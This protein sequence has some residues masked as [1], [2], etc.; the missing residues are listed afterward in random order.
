MNDE[1]CLNCRFW[2]PY[3]KEPEKVVLAQGLCRRY[4]PNVRIKGEYDRG[5][6]LMTQPMTYDEEWCGEWRGKDE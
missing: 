5:V 3:D 1:M 6:Q 2:D 4:P